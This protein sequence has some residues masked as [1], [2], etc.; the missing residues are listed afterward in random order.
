MIHLDHAE[1]T[2][3]PRASVEGQFRAEDDVDDKWRN[4]TRNHWGAFQGNAGPTW[5]FFRFVAALC[6]TIATI[7]LASA[8]PSSGLDVSP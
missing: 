6:Y 2:A 4:R 7:D 5:C 1:P 3:M 8:S